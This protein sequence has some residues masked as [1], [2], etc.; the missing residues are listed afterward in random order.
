[1]NRI[2][3]L[4]KERATYTNESPAPYAVFNSIT[5]NAAVGD[6]RN[7]VR[8]GEVGS[9]DPYRDEIEVEPGKEYEVY[10]YYHNNAASNTNESGFGMATNARLAS[11]YP[12]SLK[13]GE[14]G[15]ISGI[16]SWSFV[17][18]EDPNTARAATVWDEAY[19]TTKTDGVVLRYKAGSAV[20][21][22]GGDANGLVLPDE[23]FTVEGAPIGYNKLE[24]TVPGCA[25]Y[26]GYITYILV[27]S[28]E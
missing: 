18:P 6:E 20:I 15:M 27:A 14:R 8:I 11:A 26:S 22:N 5:N 16:I 25:E 19:V 2:E 7:F 1:M 24:G 12:T 3:K 9:S 13:V 28:K 4:D 21:H 23:L 10:I 17:T